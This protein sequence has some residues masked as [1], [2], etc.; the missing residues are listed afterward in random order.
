MLLDITLK[1][2]PA[3][4]KESNQNTNPALVGHLGTHFDVMDREFPLSYTKRKGIVFDVSSITGAEI[5]IDDISPAAI[6]KD[7]FVAFYTG[8]IEKIPYGTKEYFASHPQLSQALID[9]LLSKGVSIIGMDCAGIRC[10]KEH[11]PADQKCADKG[12]FVIENLCNLNQLL[13][14]DFIVH[15]YPM[16][17][18]GITGLPCRVIAEV[19]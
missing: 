12:T 17:Y 15:T 18:A 3:M 2:T 14:K 11:I 19:L 9:L 1:I 5:D 4:A 8:Y 6:G 10:G 7:M 16:S 13:G